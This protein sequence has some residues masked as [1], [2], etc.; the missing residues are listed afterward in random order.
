[1][2][3]LEQAYKKN[4]CLFQFQQILIFSVESAAI[5]TL[6]LATSAISTS[7]VATLLS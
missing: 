1:M 7:S 2:L 3:D 6:G 4:A 5:Y